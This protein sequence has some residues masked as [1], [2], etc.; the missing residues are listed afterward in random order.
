MLT[1]IA[2][3][4]A[5]ERFFALVD[6]SGDCWL[7][8]GAVDRKGFGMFSVGPQFD[9]HGKRRNS[10]V[11]AQRFA[12]TMHNGPIPAGQG[13]HG[14]CVLHRC[15]N[16]G[17]VNPAHLYLGTALDSVRS[18]DARGRRVNAPQVGDAHWNAKLTGAKVLEIKAMLADGLLSQKRIAEIYGVGSTTI[19][20]IN[21]GRLWSHIE[22]N[23]K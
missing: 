8:T 13:H 22:V 3:R 21:T 4:E 19:N 17:C 2:D 18:M 11:L 15:L 23:T 7:W 20:H 9:Q 10:M 5:H 1:L 12:Y 14:N 6:V 16:H